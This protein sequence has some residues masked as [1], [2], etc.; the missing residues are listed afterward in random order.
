MS[1]PFRFAFAP[2]QWGVV[3]D[4]NGENVNKLV[5]PLDFRYAGMDDKADYFQPYL[6]V[7]NQDEDI[8]DPSYHIITTS[9]RIRT[10]GGGLLY[11][12]WRNIGYR[13]D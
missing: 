1:N 2:S 7:E 3:L 11:D 6:F 12:R 8:F 13:W 5:I 9:H 4:L 10:L